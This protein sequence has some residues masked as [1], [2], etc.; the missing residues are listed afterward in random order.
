MNGNFHY[1]PSSPSLSNGNNDNFL[2]FFFV[3]L[4]RDWIISDHFLWLME[5]YT[6]LDSST[7][8]GMKISIHFYLFHVD[9]SLSVLQ[10]QV[11]ASCLAR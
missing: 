7:P 8:F 1:K 3:F 6:S 9:G 5:N 4:A 11:A 2:K 10:K